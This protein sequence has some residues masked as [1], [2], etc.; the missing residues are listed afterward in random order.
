MRLKGMM[1]MHDFSCLL[2]AR[3]AY[4]FF[5][6]PSL[7]LL[8]SIQVEAKRNSVRLD[9]SFNVFQPA[10]VP[11]RRKRNPAR[12]P[13]DP[14]RGSTSPSQESTPPPSAAPKPGTSKLQINLKST[15]NP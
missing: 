9:F 5:S 12:K 7:L 3:F 10:D 6:F 15:K 13:S 14:D 2:L 8:G 11:G 1:M 4:I